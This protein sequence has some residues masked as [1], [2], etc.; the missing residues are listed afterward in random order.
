[1]FEEVIDTEINLILEFAKGLKHQ[2]QFQDQHPPARRCIVPVVG[3][4]VYGKREED[5]LNKESNCV[6]VEEVN[7]QCNVLLHKAQT[8]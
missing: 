4:G 2:V 5:E 7:K 8:C 1:M 3:E 6:N